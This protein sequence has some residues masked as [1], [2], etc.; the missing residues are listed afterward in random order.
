[1]LPEK[2]RSV[3]C[4]AQ[5]RQEISSAPRADFE[6]PTLSSGASPSYSFGSST[7]RKK[8]GVH[9]SPRA[10]RSFFSARWISSSWCLAMPAGPVSPMA[11]QGVKSTGFG[12][13]ITKGM[14]MCRG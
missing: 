12:G 10:S 3:A 13:M 7:V 9:L 11:N 14:G 2:E 8:R 1:M 6:L 5:D 4:P